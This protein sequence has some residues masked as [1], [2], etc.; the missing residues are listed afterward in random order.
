MKWKKL[1][2][3]YCPDGSLPWAKNS[4]L[5]P[6]PILWSENVIRVYGAVRDEKGRGRIIFIDLQADNPVR[7]LRVSPAPVLDLGAPGMFDDN[8]VILGDVIATPSEWR[9]YYVGFQLVHGVKFL[10]YSGLAVSRDQGE[11]FERAR[12]TPILDRSP[13]STF[14]RAIHS[15]DFDG[16]SW[17]MWLG[18]GSAFVDIEGVPYPSYHMAWVDSP[19]GLTFSSP[20][21]RVHIDLGSDVY[22]VG[23][24]RFCRYQDQSYLFYTYGTLDKGYHSGVAVTTD[25]PNTFK[26]LSV[27]GLAPSGSGWDGNSVC[28]PAPFAWKNKWYV[29]YN[30]NEYGKTGFGV[31]ELESLPPGSS[32]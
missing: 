24:P 28:Y 2:R 15:V 9:M 4:F 12:Q 31:A 16:R 17:R 13:D 14:F 20:D 22:R 21:V 1:G 26:P 3:I 27:T 6:T 8:G 5:T 10:A 19:D 25:E 11:T 30:G 7:V 18:A 29:F 32:A 23:R